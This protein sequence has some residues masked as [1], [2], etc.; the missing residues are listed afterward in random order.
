MSNQ[1]DVNTQPRQTTDFIGGDKMPFNTIDR[2][3][4]VDNVAVS[5]Q[6]ESKRQ[7]D[8]QYAS[9][10]GLD[11]RSALPFVDEVSGTFS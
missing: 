5:K 2:T 7:E 9:N 6:L 4:I 3:P 10:E 8:I 11:D 1:L